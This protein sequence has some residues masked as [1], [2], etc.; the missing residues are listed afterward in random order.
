MESNW[1]IDWLFFYWTI[2]MIGEML[3]NT[4]DSKLVSCV[5]SNNIK[6]R[7][8]EQ[9]HQD[10]EMIMWSVNENISTTT[11]L[12]N[13]P[14]SNSYLKKR[15]SQPSR[16]GYDQMEQLFYISFSWHKE[17]ISGICGTCVLLIVLC[18]KIGSTL[19]YPVSLLIQFEDR[20]YKEPM[21]NT[22]II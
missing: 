1:L 2:E 15:I 10:R 11:T 7:K 22:E 6:N 5:N 13:F 16:I 12:T 9:E 4:H 21:V 3:L 20:Q 18:L 8:A 17:R 19:L 14:F